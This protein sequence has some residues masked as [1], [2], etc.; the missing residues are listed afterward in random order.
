MP[1][2]TAPVEEIPKLPP[3]KVPIL[4]PEAASVREPPFIVVKYAAPP[5]RL[6]VPALK[7]VNSKF[8]P[9]VRLVTPAPLRALIATEPPLAVN[10]KFPA[11]LTFPSDPAA[12]AVVPKVAENVAEPP[13]E[14][15]NPLPPLNSVPT[16][17]VPFPTFNAPV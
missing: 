15:F 3:P 1:T 16:A 8:A 5:L 12:V 13:E 10:A 6:T 7:V 9:L 2:V 4:F 11:L 14:M 17:K